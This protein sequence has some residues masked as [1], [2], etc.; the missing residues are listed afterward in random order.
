[1]AWIYALN[2][3]CGPRENHARDLARHFEGWPARVFSDGAGWWCGIA[4]EDLSSNGAHTAAEAAAMTAAGRQ[5]YWLLRTAPPVYR[6]ALAGVETDEFRTYADL[7]AE[8]DLTI[9]PGLVVS[10]DIWAAAGRR[11]AFSDFAPGYRWLPYRGE[12]HR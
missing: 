9:F 2:A 5:L 10:E 1:M 4:P 6:Y 11:A 8:R 3:E 12:T 7:V